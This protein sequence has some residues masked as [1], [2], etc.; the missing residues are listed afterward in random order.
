MATIV[1]TPAGTWKAVIRKQGWPTAVK[2]FRTKCDAEDWARQTEDEMVRGVH[3]Q[4]S[5]AKAD[6]GCCLG[7]LSAGNH[8]YQGGSLAENAAGFSRCHVSK[9]C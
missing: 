8:P 6:R 3:I 7:P 5:R 4:R 1:K 9:Q 2:T